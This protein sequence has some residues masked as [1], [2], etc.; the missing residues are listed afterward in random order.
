MIR[1]QRVGK[2]KQPQFRVVVSDKRKDLFG[3]QLEIVGHYNPVANPKTIVLNADRL[4]YWLGL[5]AQASATVHNLLVSQQVIQAK[6]VT[7]WKPRKKDKTEEP[8]AA[9]PAA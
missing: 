6:K 8:P 3:P 4:K 9:S 7:A 1:L 5:G 2:K